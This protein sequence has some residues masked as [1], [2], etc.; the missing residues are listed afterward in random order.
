MTIKKSKFI[1]VIQ[2]KSAIGCNKK[3]RLNLLG[4]GL[5]GVQSCKV[6]QDTDSIRGMIYK[7][8]HLVSVTKVSS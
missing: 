7:V 2:F 5:K 4:L 1:K 6:L 3:Q 8:R